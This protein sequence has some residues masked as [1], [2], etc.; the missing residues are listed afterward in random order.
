MMVPR[1]IHVLLALGSA[2][3]IILLLLLIDL[4]D[5]PLYFV[6]LVLL[7]QLIN[8]ASFVFNAL[9]ALA[10]PPRRQ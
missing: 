10:P 2:A 9:S 3:V 1:W 8:V 4:H 5:R 7:S 6:L